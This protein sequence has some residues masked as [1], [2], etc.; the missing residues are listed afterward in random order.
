M[1]RTCRTT[2]VWQFAAPLPTWRHSPDP[3]ATVNTDP[4]QLAQRC[5]ACFGR[6]RTSSAG[7]LG[8]EAAVEFRDQTC[9]PPKKSVQNQVCIPES[10]SSTPCSVGKAPLS[11][12]SRGH[13]TPPFPFPGGHTI[14]S[15][16]GQ[17]LLFPDRPLGAGALRCGLTSEGSVVRRTAAGHPRPLPIQRRHHRLGH[18]SY[19]PTSREKRGG[20]D[21]PPSKMSQPL[22][23]KTD[24][25]R[26]GSHSSYRGQWLSVGAGA[27]PKKTARNFFR[28]RTFLYGMARGA[29]GATVLV[30]C[31]GDRPP[32]A[33]DLRG[34]FGQGWAAWRGRPAE[35]G[36]CRTSQ[37]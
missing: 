15:R 34:V 17:R 7:V 30:H 35:G 37:G 2:A 29:C 11:T 12:P 9:P 8:Q 16:H 14:K 31:G 27:K 1:R 5:I 4:S 22:F 28:G 25:R 26:G 23:A 20:G 6:R 19:L 3:S 18:T 36:G 32:A 10:A 24:I 21:F 13:I 33:A